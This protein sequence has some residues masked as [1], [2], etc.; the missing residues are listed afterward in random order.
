MVEHMTLTH[1]IISSVWDETIYWYIERCRNWYEIKKILANATCSEKKQILNTA[2]GLWGYL[3]HEQDLVLMFSHKL[4]DYIEN[5]SL[6]LHLHI[7]YK[8][9]PN[10]FRLINEFYIALQKCVKELRKILGFNKKWFPEI[11][12]IIAG[13]RYPFE[14]CFE[15]KYY[16]YSP[17][18]WNIIE[19]LKRKITTLTILKKYRI[20]KDIVLAIL[21]DYI[22]RND[23]RRYI[24]LQRILNKA[25]KFMIVLTYSVSYSDIETALKKC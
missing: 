16:H 2:Y 15:F 1:G 5:N 21:D 20:C 18:T 23:E 17:Y 10:N 19:D 6:G 12:M 4:I 11:D 24:E 25:K 9:K 22:Y 7:N 13:N 8:L 14:Y 3:W